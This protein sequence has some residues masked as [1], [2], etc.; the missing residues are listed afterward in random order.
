MSGLSSWEIDGMVDLLV[1]KTSGLPV[2]VR[3]RYLPPY[4]AMMELVDKTDLKSVGGDPVPV[5]AR[6]AAP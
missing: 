4:A 3:V 2:S 5:R 1:S 6:L